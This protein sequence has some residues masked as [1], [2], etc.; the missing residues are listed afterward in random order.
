ML[1]SGSGL[2]VS[3]YSE[4]RYTSNVLSEFMGFLVELIHLELT[5]KPNHS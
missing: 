5:N 1:T 2:G 3:Y 4:A